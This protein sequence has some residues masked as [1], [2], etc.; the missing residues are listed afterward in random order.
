M[1]GAFVLPGADVY[2][3]FI[4][5]MGRSEVV[6]N[7]KFNFYNAFSSSDGVNMIDE[8]GETIAS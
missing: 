2:G 3:E 8:A 7:E 6:R 4:D 5:Y 1:I